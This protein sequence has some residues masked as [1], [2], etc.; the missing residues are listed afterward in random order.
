MVIRSHSL[1][2]SSIQRIIVRISWAL[3]VFSS[4]GFKSAINNKKTCWYCAILSKDLLLE[5]PKN[6]LNY[7]K[8]WPV[9]C[10]WAIM[11][12]LAQFTVLYRLE[13]K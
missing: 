7:C 9:Q 4:K 11:L 12:W 1:K 8:C 6:S 3:I 2:G 13:F 10:L 5:W